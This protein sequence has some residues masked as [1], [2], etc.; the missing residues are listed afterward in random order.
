MNILDIIILICLIPAVIQGI[1]KGFISQMISIIS[2]IAGIWASVRFADLASQWLSQYI[3]ASDQVLKIS[4]FI[5]IMVLIF[6]A[7]ALIGKMLEAAIKLI[8]LGWLNRLLGMC[9]SLLKCVLILGLIAV[10][11]NSLNETFGFV[12]SEYL[13]DSTLYP[14][15]RNIAD[16]I[17][18]Y[19]KSFLTLK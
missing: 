6:I 13:A 18:P 1:R 10:A 17:F 11:F 8:M 19:L 5:M 16:V 9:L 15:I 4:S 14:I 3:T 2:L 12:K 7:L